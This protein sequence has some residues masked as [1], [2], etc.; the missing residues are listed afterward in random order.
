MKIT[1]DNVDL[2]ALIEFVEIP[3]GSFLMGSPEDEEG[4]YGDEGP[5]HK[6]TFAQPFFLGKYPVTQ[7]QWR[8]VAALP[9]VK[10]DLNPDPSHF[11]GDNRP[12]EKVSWL[13][14]IEFCDRLSRATNSLYRLPTEAE[15][16]YACRAGTTTPFHFEQTPDTALLNCWMAGSPQETTPVG[17]FPSNPW[18]LHDMHG[19]VWEWCQDQYHKDYKG[20]P[21]DGSPWVSEEELNYRVVRGGSWNFNPE[22]CRSSDRSR[23][24]PDDCDLFIGFRIACEP[25]DSQTIATTQL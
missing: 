9:K 15:W 13:D 24:A 17:S 20:A 25:G 18:G 5:Q 4:H 1:K 10:R 3:A 22:N 23:L 8:A 2:A 14:A 11:K 21:A 12:V 7:A 16:E 19:N 6:V